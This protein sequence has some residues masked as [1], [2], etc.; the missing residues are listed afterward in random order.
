[1]AAVGEVTEIVSSEPST[2]R[3]TKHEYPLKDKI[4]YT[5]EGHVETAEFF[6]LR[7]PTSR[8][9]RECA[10]LKQSFY[11][12]LKEQQTSISDDE[13]EKAKDRLNDASDEDLSLDGDE[14]LAIMSMA[15]GIELDKVIDLAVKL[16]TNGAAFVDARV[17]VNQQHIDRLSYD[18][19]ESMTGEYLKVFLLRSALENLKQT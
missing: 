16:F 2:E 8:N 10:L 6:E 18:D 17:K 13:R 5:F 19:L 9:R 11:V 14:I 7:A 1:M 12:A 4:T 15:G 3:P